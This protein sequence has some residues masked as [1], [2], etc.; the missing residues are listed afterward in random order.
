MFNKKLITILCYVLEALIV[1]K[2]VFEL[3]MYVWGAISGNP[4][5]GIFQQGINYGSFLSILL[6]LQDL[7]GNVFLYVIVAAMKSFAGSATLKLRK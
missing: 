5:I 6:L 1:L 7:G 4:P 3:V 2:T